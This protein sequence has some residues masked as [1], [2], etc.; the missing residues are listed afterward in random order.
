MPQDTDNK[1][2]NITTKEAALLLEVTPRTIQLWSDSEILKAW[3]TA[4][5][6]RRFNVVDVK[7]LKSQLTKGTEENTDKKQLRVLVIE[8]EPDLIMLYK[9]TMQGWDLPFILKTASDGYE[10]L[11]Q[12]GEWQPDVVI[13][14]IQMPNIDGIHM[15]N[16]IYK[17][18]SYDDMLIMAVSA[19]SKGDIA[20]R[21]GLPE[22]I[23]LFTKPIP[24][25]KIEQLVKQQCETKLSR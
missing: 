14:D 9:V 19:L 13:T 8:D 15:L 4:G 21:G 7:A 20:Q 24:F 10:G 16:T 6:H 18:P 12:I 23:P 3:K 1:V 11:I 2:K 25:K 22:G 17:I 5:G